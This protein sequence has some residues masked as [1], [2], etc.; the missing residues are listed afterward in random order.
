MSRKRFD[1]IFQQHADGSLEPRQQIQVGSI[2]FGPGAQIS[3]GVLLANIDFTS[4]I[5]R[6]FEVDESTKPGTWILKSVY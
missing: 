4:L 1:E 5:G 6:E 2:Q 3:K